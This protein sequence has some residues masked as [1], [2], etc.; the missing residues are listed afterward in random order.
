MNI[1]K[2][3]IY[4]CCEDSETRTIEV[5]ET[6]ENKNQRVSVI[7]INKSTGTRRRI[8]IQAARL[9]S[10][11]YRLTGRKEAALCLALMALGLTGCVVTPPVKAPPAA[12]PKPPTARCQENPNWTTN[13]EKGNPVGIFVCFGDNSQLLYTVK[14][15]PPP[16]TIGPVPASSPAIKTIKR[17]MHKAAK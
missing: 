17:T 16:S 4:E 7:S 9:A 12:V 15:M 3:Q 13:D 1:E 14:Q 6:P 5:L 2:G 11:A 10:A 8:I